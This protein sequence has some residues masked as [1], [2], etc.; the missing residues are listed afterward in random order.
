MID[1]KDLD[2]AIAKYLEQNKTTNPDSI[3]EVGSITYLG[4]A[5][6]GTTSKDD[7]T[8]AIIKIDESVAGTTDFTYPDGLFEYTKAFSGYAGYTYTI[9]KF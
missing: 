7:P 4:Y 6:Q 8:W 9:R 2:I 3:I 5:K 1:H